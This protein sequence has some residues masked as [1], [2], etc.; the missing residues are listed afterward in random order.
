[1]TSVATMVTPTHDTPHGAYSLLERSA[2]IV[3]WAHWSLSPA[4]RGC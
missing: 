2:T 4:S 1:M 3:S